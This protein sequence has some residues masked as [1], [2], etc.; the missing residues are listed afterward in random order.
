[1]LKPV[2][3]RFAVHV[4]HDELTYRSSTLERPA[5]GGLRV[6][7]TVFDR[8]TD[9]SRLVLAEGSHWVC[10]VADGVLRMMQIWQ[11]QPRGDQIVDPGTE[12]LELPLP[13]G[14]AGVEVPRQLQG[15]VVHEPDRG[16]LRL[17]AP[18]PPGGLPLRVFYSLP[19]RGPHLEL[20]QPMTVALAPALLHVLNHPGLVVGGPA[21]AGPP[22]RAEASERGEVFPLEAVP[23]GGRLELSLEGLPHRDRRGLYAVLAL[24]LGVTLWGVIG[25]LT[26]PRRAREIDDRRAQ[27]LERLER[28]THTAGEGGEEDRRRRERER[29]AVMQELRQLLEER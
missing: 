25:A 27:L 15:I 21:S 7:F 23:A 22:R 19:Y 9:T 4:R 10:Q 8:T 1:M 6:S 3:A 14:A 28:L 13:A 12:G 11:L 2:E 16:A 24:A 5:A 20:S 26:G 18:V 17:R 29:E